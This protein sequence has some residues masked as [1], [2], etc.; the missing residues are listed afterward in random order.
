MLNVK[1]WMSSD[2]KCQTL[3]GRDP[4]LLQKRPQLPLL[5]LTP[6]I[7]IIDC[8]H[9]RDW[10]HLHHIDDDNDDCWR[11][12]QIQPPPP[13]PYNNN[14][15]YRHELA[16][17]TL[18]QSLVTG[19][20][21]HGSGWPK[22]FLFFYAFPKWWYRTENWDCNVM[23]VLSF[24]SPYSWK[25]LFFLCLQVSNFWPKICNFPFYKPNQSMT[26]QPN[27]TIVDLISGL[28]STSTVS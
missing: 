28:P 9:H 10:D 3:D 7:L 15:R 12:Y 19:Y 11:G 2:V 27:P 18:V 1:P 22:I 4:R 25:E 14:G 26:M 17:G 6:C 20:I 24:I 16:M 8:D 5:L 21:I 13:P 23:M